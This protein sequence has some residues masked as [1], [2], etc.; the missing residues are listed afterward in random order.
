MAYAGPAELADLAERWATR[1]RWIDGDDMTD[2]LLT[3][4]REVAR[5][6]ATAVRTGGRLYSWSF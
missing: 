1:L 3:V 2:D 5:L 6:A 4:L